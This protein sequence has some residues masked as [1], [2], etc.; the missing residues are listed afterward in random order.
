M[1]FFGIS[2]PQA[3]LDLAKYIELAPENLHYDRTTRMYLAKSG[4]SRAFP[5][6]QPDLFLDRMLANA[7]DEP[8]S[9]GFLG[10]HPPTATV[11]IPGRR[12]SEEVLARVVAAIRNKEDIFV[13]YQ[14]ITSSVESGR[15]LSP[16]ALAHDG[17]RWHVRAYCHLRNEFRDFLIA[18]T[19]SVVDARVGS[20]DLELDTAWHNVV[21][22]RLAPHPGL[23]SAARRIVE[24]DYGMQQGEAKLECREAL[25]FYLLRQMNLIPRDE[26]NVPEAQQ[27][28]LINAEDVLPLLKKKLPSLKAGNE[29][30][31]RESQ[32]THG[33]S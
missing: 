23:T 14:S 31:P 12:V 7:R 1:Q 4:F 17:Y 5:T 22:L 32:G 3:S 29:N 27:I 30:H 8:D 28:I 9:L 20:M 6:S 16:H 2:T 13:H 33:Q 15:W 11:P 18:R 19:V 24:D 10:W 21:Q 26:S 25:L